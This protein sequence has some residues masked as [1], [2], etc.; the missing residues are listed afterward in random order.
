M[1]QFNNF[2]FL[3][4]FLWYKRASPRIITTFTKN[5]GT[6]LE[7]KD[8]TNSALELRETWTNAGHKPQSSGT[9]AN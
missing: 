6:C 1:T 9:D 5:T 8:E 3:R 2:H 4:R 7:G